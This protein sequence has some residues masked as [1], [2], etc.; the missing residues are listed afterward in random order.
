M[1]TL[2]ATVVE[3]YKSQGSYAKDPI[4]DEEE[5]DN[6]QALWMKRVNFRNV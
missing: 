5:W 3:R 2:I 6:L 4:L 1:W